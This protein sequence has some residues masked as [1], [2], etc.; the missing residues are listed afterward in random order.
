MFQHPI[1]IE[2]RVYFGDNIKDNVNKRLDEEIGINIGNYL[3]S[4]GISKRPL[5]IMP[6]GKEGMEDWEKGRLVTQV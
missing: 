2:L 6:M 1:R 4:Q 3:V 5:R